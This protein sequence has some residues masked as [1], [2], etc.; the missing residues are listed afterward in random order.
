MAMSETMMCKFKKLNRREVLARFVY[1]EAHSILES[2]SDF[3]GVYTQVGDLKRSFPTVSLMALTATIT[4]EET[5]EVKRIIKA[6]DT[7]QD[8]TFPCKWTNK[9]IS[10]RDIRNLDSQV[11]DFLKHDCNPQDTGII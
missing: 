9:K 11:L 4:A 10:V 6:S 5:A 2:S 8:F 1:D 3:R 7:C